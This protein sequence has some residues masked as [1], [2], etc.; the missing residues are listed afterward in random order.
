MTYKVHVLYD[1]YSKMADEGMVANCTCTLIKGPKHIVVDTMTPWDKE[2]IITGLGHHGVECSDVHY[3]V[4]THGH[5]DHTGNNNLF[6]NAKHI[7]GF[8]IS[9]KDLYFIHPFETGEP[10]IIDE[11]VK[12]VPTPGHTLT[13][14]SVLVN[15]KD[16]GLVAV[17]GD[18]FER[19]EDITNPS[20]WQLVAGSDDPEKQQQNRNKIMQIA[21]WIVPGHGPI[22]RVTEEMKNGAK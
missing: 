11:D 5:S 7:V 22:F 13:D 2:K 15:T 12:V 16:K 18:L 9:C 14:V 3:V 1:G 20:L 17:T 21:D 10:F 19:E 4:C 8:S 6:L